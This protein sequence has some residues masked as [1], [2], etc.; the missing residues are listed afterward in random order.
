[1]VREGL[2]GEVRFELSVERQGG[3]GQG[4]IKNLG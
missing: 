1:M 4:R 3:S 2:S